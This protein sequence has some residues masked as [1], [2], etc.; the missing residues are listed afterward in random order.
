[1]WAFHPLDGFIDTVKRRSYDCW[2]FVIV[3]V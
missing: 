1:M 2:C 3:M